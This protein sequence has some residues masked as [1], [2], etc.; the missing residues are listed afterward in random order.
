MDAATLEKVF[1]P[2]FT[3][4]SK[5]DQRGTGLG[6][7]MVS[8]IVQQYGGRIDV[9]SEP[10]RGTTFDVS[11]P[12]VSPAIAKAQFEP[13]MPAGI[14]H[15][16]ILLIDDEAAL[17]KLGTTVLE[18]LGYTVT[19]YMDG[20]EAVKAFAAAPDDFDLVITDYAMHAMT[21][22]ELIDKVRQIR[23]T[24]PTI[25]LTGFTNLINRDNIAAWKCDSIVAKP[26]SM[27][28]LGKAIRSVL[29]NPV[30]PDGIH[31]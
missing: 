10:N 9:S 3:T 1:D 30:E 23:A 13:E 17:C 6:L 25:L 29:A 24:V 19:A 2:F 11:F 12:I 27:D 5:A 26:F 22:P 14:G 16:R 31:H 18:E 4:K 8:S 7:A 20:A 28:Q 21:G 15:A